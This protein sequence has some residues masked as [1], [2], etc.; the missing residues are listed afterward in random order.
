M[1]LIRNP[2]IVAQSKKNGTKQKLKLL[3]RFVMPKKIKSKELCVRVMN[4]T[5]ELTECQLDAWLE[6]RHSIDVMNRKE[7]NDSR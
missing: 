4:W 7:F 1:C 2:K 5:K 6:Q 3:D